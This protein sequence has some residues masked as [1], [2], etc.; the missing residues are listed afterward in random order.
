M[1]HELRLE[2]FHGYLKAFNAHSLLELKQFYHP[3]CKVIIDGEIIAHDRNSMM[4]NYADVWREMGTRTVDALDIKGI[5]H[6]L[7]VV[8]RIPSDAKDITV[9]YI[10]DDDGL[11]IAHFLNTTLDREVGLLL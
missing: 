8:L 10:F 3:N 5:Q 9:E 1:D 11:Q 2:R 7:R 6:G 4:V